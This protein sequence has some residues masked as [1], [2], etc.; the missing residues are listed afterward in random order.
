MIVAIYCIA[1]AQ[2]FIRSSQIGDPLGPILGM[3]QDFVFWTDARGLV[4][5]HTHK[6]Y[7]TMYSI[8]IR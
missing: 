8:E 5:Q 6:Y 7:F 1:Y 3:Y 2:T 4:G